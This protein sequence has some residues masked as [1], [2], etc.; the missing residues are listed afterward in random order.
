[1]ITFHPIEARIQGKRLVTVPMVRAK[2]PGGWLV[3][4][5]SGMIHIQAA[6]CFVPDP[7]HRWDG[8]SLPEP[9]KEQTK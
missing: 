9:A 2:V 5:Q 8:S 4:L 3:A 6:V 7:E 1:M